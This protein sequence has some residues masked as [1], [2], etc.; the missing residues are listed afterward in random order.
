MKKTFWVGMAACIWCGAFALA[1]A[2]QATWSLLC[3]VFRTQRI[4]MPGGEGFIYVFQQNDPDH[5]SLLSKV[6][7]VLGGRTAGYF[8]RQ[9]KGFDHFYL[10]IPASSS[11]G[12]EVS[13]YTVQD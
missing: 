2:Q 11:A 6:P 5:Y 12:A 13:I 8:G 3:R 1:R 10:A 9:G 7:T 4:Y